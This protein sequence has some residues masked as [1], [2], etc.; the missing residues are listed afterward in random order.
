MQNGRRI[1]EFL[2]SIGAV[3]VSPQSPFTWTSGMQSPVYCDNRMLY[4]HPDART[5]VVQALTDRVRNL[6]IPPDVVAGTSTAAIGWAALVADRLQLPFVYVRATAKEYGMKKRIEGDLRPEQHVVLIEDLV[7]TGR[8][9]VESVEALREEGAAVVTD[10]VS[11][12]SYGLESA[13]ERAQRMGLHLHP[14]AAFDVLLA[15]AEEQGRI[16]AVQRASLLEFV[17]DPERWRPLMR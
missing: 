13:A 3:K 15:A 12:V 11:I 16:D 7:A 8:S 5:L 6:H 4:S 17:R 14:L 10:V 1:A 2:L 9:T